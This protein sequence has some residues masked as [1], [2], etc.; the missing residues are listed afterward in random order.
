M[1]NV[2]EADLLLVRQARVAGWQRMA[3]DQPNH[4]I[5][6]VELLRTKPNETV[7]IITVQRR[8]LVQYIIRGDGRGRVRRP[9]DCDDPT[10]GQ[11]PKGAAAQTASV[12]ASAKAAPPPDPSDPNAM[13]LGE[14][15]PKEP[16]PPG[17]AALGE[18]LL[19]TAFDLG[20]VVPG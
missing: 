19:S 18:V 7:A 12:I 10:T 9:E 3:R 14:P 6:A 2:T 11:D 20:E 16:P 8:E 1:A 17:I 15:P 4:R 13:P 5:L